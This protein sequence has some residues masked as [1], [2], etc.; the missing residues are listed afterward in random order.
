MIFFIFSKLFRLPQT[1][2]LDAH[3]AENDAKIAL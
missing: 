3:N 2:C 1:I